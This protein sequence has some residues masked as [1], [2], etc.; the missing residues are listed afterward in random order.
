MALCGSAAVRVLIENNVFFKCWW[1]AHFGSISPGLRWHCC[2]HQSH[3]RAL[4]CAHSAMSQ[5]QPLDHLLCLFLDCCLRLIT[6][7]GH[8]HFHTMTT[9]HI[10]SCLGQYRQN[11]SKVPSGIV[12]K[13]KLGGHSHWWCHK[14]IDF[15]TVWSVCHPYSCVCCLKSQD[16]NYFGFLL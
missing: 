10:P 9:F 7:I 11:L 2:G 8:K 16:T 13:L 1:K 4:V 5:T 3:Q 6:I 12:P 14:R 15:G